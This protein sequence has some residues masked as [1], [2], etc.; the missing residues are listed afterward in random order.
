MDILFMIVCAIFVIGFLVFIHEGGH[1]LAARVFGV[2]VTEF[3]LGLPGPSIGFKKAGTRFGV[4]A[5]PLGGY[6]KVCGM[7]MGPI[8]EHAKAVLACVYEQ[9]TASLPDIARACDIS[10]EE[11]QDTLDQ[12]VEWGSV[13]APRKHDAADL[14]RTPAEEPTRAQRRVAARLCRPLSTESAAGTPRAVPDAHALFER[15]LSQQY[16][17]LPFWKRSVIL[18][19]GIAVNLA[20]ALVAFIVIYSVIG[21]DVADPETGAITHLVVGPDRAIFAGFSYIGMTVQAIMG[22]FN[23]ATAVETVSNSTSVIGI[24]VMS[25]DYFAAGLAEALFFMAV[26]SVSLGLMNLIPIPPLDGG[27]FLI[28][29]IQKLSRRQVPARVMGYL[30]LA[31]M[32][33][34]IGF[35]VIMLN[36]DVQRFIFGNW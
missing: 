3:M 35:F 31:G 13:E 28:E 12:L 5:V 22:L 29:V 16:R 19:A 18:L 2:R 4:T 26:I 7:E 21:F 23:P 15:E 8:S 6:A 24:A 1:Y 11:A 33:L 27:R 36:Q 20:F 25:A 30:S 10:E 9:G 34:F 17:S 14:Y 32:A